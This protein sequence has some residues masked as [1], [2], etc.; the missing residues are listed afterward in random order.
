MTI[1]GHKE[2]WLPLDKIDIVKNYYQISN[3]GRIYSGWSQKLL[4]PIKKSNGYLRVNLQINADETMKYHEK[5]YSV[6]RLVAMHFIPLP[7][8]YKS[9]DELQVNHKTGDKEINYA[10]ELEWVGSENIHHAID[11]KLI[12]APVG[13]ESKYHKYDSDTVRLICQALE[14]GFRGKKL[15]KHCGLDESYLNLV[16][17]IKERRHW[18]SVSMNYSF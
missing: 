4:K 1:D 17:R 5:E 11:N 8:G 15:L 3:F 2:K 14:D 7:E 12:V 6:H 18:V 16:R 13:D 9:F 10:W